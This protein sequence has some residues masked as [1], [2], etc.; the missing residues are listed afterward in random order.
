MTTFSPTNSSTPQNL[1]GQ[2]TNA[3]PQTNLATYFGNVQNAY[4]GATPIYGPDGNITG[5]NQPNQTPSNSA[6]SNYPVN[7]NGTF[8]AGGAGGAP[9]SGNYNGTQYTAG[10]PTG[11]Q[12]PYS[13]NYINPNN[14]ASR[15]SG[16]SIA[17]NPG[18]TSGANNL[19]SAFNS[20]ADV[21]NFNDLLGNEQSGSNALTAGFNADQNTFATVPGQ[22][23]GALNANVNQFA[24]TGNTLNQN[25][26]SVLGNT[27]AAENS[28][29]NQATNLLPAYD[30]AVTNVGNQE[31]NALAQDVSRYKLGTGTPGSLGSGEENLLIQGTQAAQVPLEEAKINQNYNLLQNLDLPVAQ[32]QG[33]AAVN[34]ITGFEEPLAAANYNNTAS[35][36]NNIAQLSLQVAGMSIADATKYMQAQGIPA[37]VQQQILSGNV[38]NLGGINNILGQSQYQGLQDVLGANLSQPTASSFVAP[39][40]QPSRYSTP[41]ASPTP[42]QGNLSGQPGQPQPTQ[43]GQPQMTRDAAG[44][45]Y[46]WAANPYTGQFGWQYVAPAGRTLASPSSLSPQDQQASQ[47]AQYQQANGYVPVGQSA[48]DLSAYDANQDASSGVGT[49]GDF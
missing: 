33:Q 15:Y 44:N 47:E 5:W 18:I 4:A 45:L 32:Q 30:Q 9:Y 42:L 22:T 40:V 23:A 29:V 46:Q 48:P 34:Q 11:V 3:S 7:V 27:N 35:T 24:N 17:K 26:S 6:A 16:V 14:A 10:N 25:Y 12:V 28:I 1:A 36:A 37:Q 49:V 21:S 38:S 39:G 19:L 8:L 2:T 43:P 41:S 13:T 20:G 31:Q